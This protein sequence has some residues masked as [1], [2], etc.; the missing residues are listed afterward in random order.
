M[1]N[2]AM[3]RHIPPGRADNNETGARSA[4]EAV[5]PVVYEELRELAE[6]TLGHRGRS[7]TLQPTALVHE[8]YLRLSKDRSGWTDRNN[9]VV[10]ASVAM[11]RAR[12]SV[13]RRDGSAT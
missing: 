13:P 9:F 11:R 8:A 10:A 1:N 2:G 4:L 7:L 12:W 6:K 3:P 5:L